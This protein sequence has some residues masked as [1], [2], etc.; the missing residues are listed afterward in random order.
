LILKLLRDHHEY[1]R[2]QGVPAL[3]SGDQHLNAALN[4]ILDSEENQLD[5]IGSHIAL[6]RKQLKEQPN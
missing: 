6:L 4:A 5:K 3:A 2:P 1:H